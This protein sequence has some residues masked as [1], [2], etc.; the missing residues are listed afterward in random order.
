MKNRF[1]C[2]CGRKVNSIRRENGKIVCDY[3]QVKNLSGQWERRINS[4]R[5]KYEKDILQPTDPRFNEVYG[6]GKS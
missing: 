5:Q 3:C 4:E 2:S 1:I 6:K